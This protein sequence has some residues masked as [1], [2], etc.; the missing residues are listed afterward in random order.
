MIYIPW[1]IASESSE[2]PYAVL[3]SSPNWPLAHLLSNEPHQETTW[4]LQH[5]DSLFGFYL[6]SGFLQNNHVSEYYPKNQTID[7]QKHWGN[8]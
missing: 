3:P 7:H 8:P 4:L 5:H 6:L 2:W 1:D